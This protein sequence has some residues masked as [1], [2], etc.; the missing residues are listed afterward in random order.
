[1]PPGTRNSRK[2]SWWHAGRSSGRLARRRRHRRASTANKRR[3]TERAETAKQLHNTQFLRRLALLAAG[4]KALVAPA[5]PVA[6]TQL[7][8]FEASDMEGAQAPFGFWDPAGFSNTSP[9]ALCWFRAAELK[10]GR[11]A[12]LACMGFIAQSYPLTLLKDTPIAKA[13]LYPKLSTVDVTF[14]DLAAA[15]N[16]VEQFK[17]IPTLGLWQFAFVAG[18]I[19][20]YAEFQ[21]PHYLRGGAHRARDADLGPRRPVD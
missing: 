14:G 15:G 20:T 16:P 6:R 8:A 12:M 10:H 17:L 9:E 5:A 3:W 4:A 13:S 18:M 1:M 2:S 11:V 19:E 7:R 21:K